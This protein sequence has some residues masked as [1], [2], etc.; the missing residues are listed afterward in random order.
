MS[1]LNYSIYM[2]QMTVKIYELNTQNTKQLLIQQN[3]D[4]NKNTKIEINN[5]VLRD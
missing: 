2:N 3:D 5:L 4:L 1:E